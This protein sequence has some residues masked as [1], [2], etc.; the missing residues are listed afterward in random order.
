MRIGDD[1]GSAAAL[2]KFLALCGSTTTARCAFSAGGPKATRTKFD[3]LMQR[4]KKRPVG[5][6]TYALTVESAATTLYG[7]ERWAPLAKALQDL[8][9]GRTPAPLPLPPEIPPGP[10][11]YLGQEQ[12]LGV[13]CG[14]NP[15][16][17]DPAAYPALEKLSVNRAGDVGHYWAWHSEA[18]ATWPARAASHY[19]GPWN[20]PTP[21][22]LLVVNATHDPATP[23]HG[24]Q[25]LTRQLANARLLTVNGY[26]HSSLVNPSSC[27]NEFESRYLIDGTLPPTGTVCQQNTHPFTAPK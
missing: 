27:V 25:A 4:L 1:I 24:A 15:N 20:T 14:E 6:W 3:Q 19:T 23:Y 10:L 13:L 18:C 22:P 2:D 11:P 26:G 7:V 17:R 8:W 9:Q 5:A 21:R 16:P 12:Q